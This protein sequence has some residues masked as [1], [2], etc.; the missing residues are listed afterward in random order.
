[1]Y[2]LLKPQSVKYGRIKNPKK[3]D[4]IVKITVA[5][6]RDNDKKA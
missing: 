4:D 3:D 5:T 2:I 6:D 1:M